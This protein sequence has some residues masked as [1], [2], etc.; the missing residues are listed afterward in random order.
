MAKPAPR[1]SANSRVLCELRVASKSW[2]INQNE[3]GKE[4]DRKIFQFLSC[5]PVFLILSA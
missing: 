1:I 5:F 2:C 4:K 3:L